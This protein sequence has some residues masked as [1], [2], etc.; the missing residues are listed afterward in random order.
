M[1]AAHREQQ[2]NWLAALSLIALAAVWGATFFMVKDATQGFSVLAFLALR[3]TIAALALAPFV[4]GV[5][6]VRRPPRR[7][8]LAGIG[9][10]LLFCGGYVFQT[11]SLR[12][13]DSGRVGFI[14]GLYVIFVP[15]LALILLRYRLAPGVLLGAALALVGMILLGYAPGGNLLGDTLALLC[16]LSFA[17]HILAVGNLPRSADWRVMALLQSITVAVICGV[18]LPILAALRACDAPVCAALAPFADALPTGIPLAVW[19]VA[20]FTGL[21]ATAAGLGVQV[22]AQRLLPPSNA[23]L[24][25]ALESP[26]AAL[27]GVAFRGEVLSPGGLLGCALIFCGTL[28]ATLVP[29]RRERAMPAETLE[30]EPA[31]PG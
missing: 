24:I 17:A 4:L 7:E 15:F 23:A 10:G 25:F 19:A 22:W 5:L 26:F 11:F 20:A 2:A 28:T 6:R 16:A 14:T 1:H 27:F 13:V 3:F 30:I 29:E 21:V 18:L 9:A 31:D 8:I 12:A